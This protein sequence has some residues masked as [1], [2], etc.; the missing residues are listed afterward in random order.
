MLERTLEIL[1]VGEGTPP[2]R[3]LL[4]ALGEEGQGRRIG[5]AELR[6]VGYQDDPRTVSEYYRA[7]DI[8][9]HAARA[10]T[11]PTSVIEA[12]ACGTPV[13]ATAVGGI[14]EQVTSL[15]PWGDGNVET[16]RSPTGV[17]VQPRDAQEMAAAVRRL[18]ADDGLLERLGQ[19]AAND[20]S[21]RFA[22]D[23]QVD[24]YLDWYR[25]IL[26]GNDS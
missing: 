20:A 21:R 15:Y 9:L 11:F 16:G 7:A 4:I 25:S 6:F 17:L 22:L 10:D 8:Y 24:A 19:N 1:G 2:A 14:P 13:V 23:A 3:I 26:I 12:A 5:S 18:L